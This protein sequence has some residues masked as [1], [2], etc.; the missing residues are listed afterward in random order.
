MKQWK[1][2]ALAAGLATLLVACA[3][4]VPDSGSSQPAAGTQSEGSLGVDPANFDRSVRPQDDFYEFVNG[5]WLA[6]TEI[7]SDRSRWGTF[8]ELREQATADVHAIIEDAAASRADTDDPDVAK[9]ADLYASFM[10]TAA[11][12]AAGLAPI[13][14]MLTRIDRVSDHRDLARLFGEMHAAGL[15]WLTPMGFWMDLDFGD[16]DRYALYFTQSG[17]GMP[18]R[19]Y[20]L[21]EE[22]RFVEVR[23]EYRAYIRRLFELAGRTPADAAAAADAIIALE[24]KLA[25]DQWTRAD[26]RDR[27]KT[28][29]PT[30]VDS[31]GDVVPGF[32]WDVFMGAAG[33]SSVNQV[34]LREKSYFPALGETFTATDLDTW[35][36]YLRFKVLDSAAPYLPAPFVEA[37]FEFEGRTLS[38]TPEIRP[39]WKRA[40]STVESVMGEAVGRL[41]VAR[42]FSPE[43][44]ARMETMVGNLKTA[45][46]QAIDD[47]VWMTAPTKS[48]AQA[49]LA[50]FGLKIGYPDKWRDYSELEI[51]PD[52]LF[53][54]VLRSRRFEYEYDISRLGGPV[55]RDEWGMTPQTVNAYYSP[56]RNEIVFPAAILQP[57]FFNPEADEAVN[58]GAIGGVIGHEFSHGFDDQGRRTDGKGLLRDWWTPADDSRYRERADRLV[59]QY[60]QYEPIE[61][62]P[63]NGRLSLGENIGDL[64]GVTMAYRAWKLSLDGQEPAVIDGFTGSQRF[65]MGWAQIW[66]TKYREEALRRQLTVGP[67]SPGHY[68]VNGVVTNIDGFFEAFDVDTADGMWRPEEDRVRIW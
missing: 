40:V 21:A 24:T 5:T 17:L 34:I 7:P 68:R 57:P 54:N 11:I 8:D 27:Q 26:R 31:L 14:P 63:I 52:D 37:N 1:L 22:G 30:A 50:S 3:A 48:E 49:K 64:A 45:F 44:K 53:G 15:G 65:F 41:Y 51:R 46:G 10:D 4:S 28:Y 36:E 25:A 59:A 32:E 9:I 6:R 23:G 19:E 2:P 38:G 35:R 67:H 62:M 42:H 12:D 60:E 18:D 47:L 61:G 56:T 13:A 33:L 55:D 58:Y 39:R 43:S 20:Y 66:R 16:T 29:N